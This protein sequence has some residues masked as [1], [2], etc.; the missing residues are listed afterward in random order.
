MELFN[1]KNL[2]FNFAKTFVPALWVSAVVMVLSLVGFFAPGLN[3]G[4]DFRGGVDAHVKFFNPQPDQSE[5]RSVVETVLPGSTVVNFANTTGSKEYSIVVPGEKKDEA[6]SILMRSLESKFG[7]PSDSSWK[8]ESMDFVGP[9][10]GAQLRKEALLALFYTLL[11]IT[12]YMYWRFDLR[13]APGACI[14]TIH[15]LLITVGF[16]IAIQAEFSTTVVAALLTLAGYSINDT[17]VVYDRI[18]ELDAAHPG[19]DKKSLINEAINSTLSRTVITG[20]TTL[21]ALCVIWA[22]MGPTLK[23]FSITLIFG[24]LVGT[25]SSIF[26]AAP[27]YWISDRY[28]GQ[29]PNRA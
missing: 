25:L 28:F 29:N 18:R 22:V 14:A 2:K 1:P 23:E 5:L 17:V 6:S 3:Y 24:I 7:T 15:D 26:V 9:K 8:L 21:I 13:Y 12:L 10:V 27:L 4:V 20:G 11:V 19:R 16:L